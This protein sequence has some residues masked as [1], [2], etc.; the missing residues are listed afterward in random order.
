MDRQALCTLAQL[1][2]D[3]GSTRSQA[4][5]H[6]FQ[7]I[8]A[9]A[10][11]QKR[12][13]AATT[14]ASSLVQRTKIGIESSDTTWLPPRFQSGL[15]FAVVYPSSMGTRMEPGLRTLVNLRRSA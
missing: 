12:I 8:C 5:G 4:L 6:R 15:Q 1:D 13:E 7:A 3:P 14:S 10:V 9:E 11:H 2:R